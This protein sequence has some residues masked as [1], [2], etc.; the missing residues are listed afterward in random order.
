MRYPV[1]LHETESKTYSGFAPDVKGCIFAGNT[2]DE[3]LADAVE[4][5]DLHIE[6]LYDHGKN[7][8]EAK[9]INAHK[10]NDSCKDGIWAFVDVDITKYEGKAIRLNISLPQNLVSR[11]D[12]YVDA[13]KE[14]ES[15]SS[16]IAD[17][18]RRVLAQA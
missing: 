9:T 1:Y 5:I 8:P 17:I 13:H 10:D 4:A 2:V 11:I 12:T 6:S 16:F 3:A 18:A 7:I 14:I 15:R